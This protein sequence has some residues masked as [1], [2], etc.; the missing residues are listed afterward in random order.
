M[1]WRYFSVSNVLVTLIGYVSK[2]VFE[3]ASRVIRGRWSYVFLLIIIVE[4][5]FA[6]D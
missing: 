1:R 6:F 2:K 3:L 5:V 4:N